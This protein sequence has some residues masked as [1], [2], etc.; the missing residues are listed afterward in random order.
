MVSKR[1]L[2]LSRAGR[3][4]DSVYLLPRRFAGG[5][6]EQVLADRDRLREEKNSMKEGPLSN[7]RPFFCWTPSGNSYSP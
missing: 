4:L 1:I 6:L 5:V 3:M 7:Q 2:R